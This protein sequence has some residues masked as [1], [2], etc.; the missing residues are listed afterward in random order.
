[1]TLAETM[2]PFLQDG[3]TFSNTD[4]HQA[5]YSGFKVTIHHQDGLIVVEE[6]SFSLSGP[7]Q[8]KQ[9]RQLTADEFN[10][11]VEAQS[12]WLKQRLASWVTYRS[13]PD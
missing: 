9:T 3:L 1:M 7:R 12:K 5:A 11:W 4:I 13:S 10:A 2:L 6:L 8:D